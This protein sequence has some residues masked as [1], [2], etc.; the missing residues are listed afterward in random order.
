M[1]LYLSHCSLNGLLENS[2]L[3]QFQLSV[4]L[5]CK[6]LF[7]LPLQSSYQSFSAQLT[8]RK[9]ESNDDGESGERSYNDL[10]SKTQS[11]QRVQNVGAPSYL[12]LTN[13]VGEK[14]KTRGSILGLSASLL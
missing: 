5:H 7:N 6:L 14:E 11:L 4:C 12:H 2:P 1:S 13:K 9:R 3:K 10:E 8:S